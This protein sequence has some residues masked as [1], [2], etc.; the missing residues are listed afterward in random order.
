MEFCKIANMVDLGLKVGAVK[1][2]W[3]NYNAYTQ[4]RIEVS[5]PKCFGNALLLFNIL[6]I[7]L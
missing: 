7:Y 2:N 4:V 1:Q 3:K 5:H 6:S